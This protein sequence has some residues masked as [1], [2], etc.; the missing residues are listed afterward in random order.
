MGHQVGFLGAFS[1]L[2]VVLPLI[3][4]IIFVITALVLVSTVSIPCFIIPASTAAI[5]F[6]VALVSPWFDAFGCAVGVYIGF[7]FGGLE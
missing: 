2:I 1:A 5:D 3:A 7:E 6:W 4:T